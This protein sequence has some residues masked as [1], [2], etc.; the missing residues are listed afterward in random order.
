MYPFAQLSPSAGRPLVELCS[1][2]P[3]A[4]AN[5]TKNISRVMVPFG[6]IRLSPTPFIMPA[7]THLLTA[8]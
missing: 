8:S 4:R 7:L 2:M 6:F 5:I 1:F 3:R